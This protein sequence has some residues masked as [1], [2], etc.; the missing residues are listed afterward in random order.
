MR[1]L[2]LLLLLVAFGALAPAA[3][4][5]PCFTTM[6]VD[7]VRTATANGAHFEAHGKTVSS[8]KTIDDFDITIL[9][10]L[11]DGVAIDHD[12]II[13][14]V[15]DYAA[16]NNDREGHLGRHVGLAG[17]QQR[18]QADRRRRVRPRDRRVADR[19]HHAR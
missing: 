9:G 7:A 1:R 2:T 19:G 17:L 14:Q 11:D 16:L 12:M 18:R 6:S 10:V 8:G 4:A 13:G 15:H 5:A 3:H